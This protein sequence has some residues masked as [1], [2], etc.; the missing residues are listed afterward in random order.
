MSLL[1]QASCPY[2]GKHHVLTRASIMSLRGQASCPNKTETD[3]TVSALLI[4]L[5]MSYTIEKTS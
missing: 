3:F 4:L 2:E 5:Y 1:G